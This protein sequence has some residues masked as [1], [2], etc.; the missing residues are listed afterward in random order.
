MKLNIRCLVSSVNS[1]ELPESE[2]I[3]K[4]VQIAN[5][6]ATLLQLR[7]TAAV[8]FRLNAYGFT[9]IYCGEKTVNLSDEKK[10]LVDCGLEEGD[11]IVLI[12][13][14]L[15]SENSCM[16]EN[17]MKKD[18]PPFSDTLPPLKEARLEL[19]EPKPQIT[20]AI[21]TAD[22]LS[23]AILPTEVSTTLQNAL[24]SSVSGNED[25]NDD[26]S[27]GS[28]NDDLANSLESGES[29]NGSCELYS[30]LL[31]IAPN[32]VEMRDSFLADPR[33]V[34][35]RVK[36]E[37]PTLS[38][39]IAENQEEFLYLINNPSLVQT[40]QA[41]K[42]IQYT[43]DLFN[44][45]EIEEIP[46]EFLDLFDEGALEEGDEIIENVNIDSRECDKESILAYAPSEDDEKKI[47]QLVLLGF[48]YE[49][50]KLAFYRCLRSLE[51][52]ANTL[53]ENPPE[54]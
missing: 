1:L 43:D 34:L 8:Q 50:S 36:V 21:D 16:R 39:L 13:K 5:P 22:S 47:Q 25:N 52:A 45:E 51:R 12:S 26:S 23:S 17:E 2:V 20:D 9:M 44:D 31:E 6:R 48:S 18:Q 10:L 46:E 11:S 54:L 15:R 19:Q 33:A 7:A 41:E 28:E 35:E 49:Q 42:E 38:K 30:R 29:S 4:E 24:E 40:L 14:H 37:D 27:I 53:F 3:E 32:L